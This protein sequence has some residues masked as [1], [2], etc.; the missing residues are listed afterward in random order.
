MAGTAQC[1]FLRR[2][3]GQSPVPERL[4]TVEQ[5]GV[6]VSLKPGPRY[7]EL[8]CELPVTP[9]DDCYEPCL[10]RDGRFVVFSS[11]A[12]NLVANDQN[13][14][15]DVFCY[16]RQTSKVELISHRPDGHPGNGPSYSPTVSAD[17]SVIAF[18]SRATDLD[19]AGSLVYVW[20]RASGRVS[21]EPGSG[22]GGR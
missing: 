3:P 5:A 21:A 22:D 4:C 2:A 17:G 7:L 9:N 20:E 6:S 1:A 11:Y 15:S 13:R 16:D 8:T 19:P 10:S 18:A 12:S 14:T